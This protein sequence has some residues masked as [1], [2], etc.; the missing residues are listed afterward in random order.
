MLHDTNR[1]R[2]GL[3]ASGTRAPAATAAAALA[4]ALLGGGTAALAAGGPLS[5]SGNQIVDGTGTPVR[6]AGV[7]W[8]GFETGTHV[9]HGLWT[10]N[11]KELLQQVKDLGFNT[12]RI[13]WCNQAFEPGATTNSINTW[14]NPDLAG[15]SPIQVLDKIVDQCGVLGLRI[16]L[17]RHS[18]IADNFANED[19]WY[20]PGSGTW[21]EERWIADWVMLANRYAGNH[22]VIGA[23]LFNEPKRTATWGAGAPATDWNEAAERAGN[24]IL[25]ANPE[26]LIFV[27]GVEKANGQSTWWGGNL[28]AAATHPVTLD[29]PGRLVYSMHDYPASVYAQSWFGAPNYPA[30]LPGVWHGFWG[31]LFQENTAPLLLGEFGTKLQTVSDQQ[32][33]STLLAYAGGDFNLDGQ[34]DLTGNQKGMSWTYWSL[35]PNSGD[36]GGILADNWITVNQAKMT[37]LAGSLAPL[38]GSSCQGDLDGSGAVDGADLGSLLAAW[39]Q[40]GPADLDGSG[41]VDGA[42]LGTLLAAWGACP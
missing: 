38:I 36:T 17:D 14:A 20:I 31:Y 30:N 39:G 34:S 2:G 5:T 28:M 4:S 41:A 3:A 22:T 24:A 21:T 33:L 32:W 11:W 40:P 19:L 42:D 10:R 1:T 13:P 23:D 9:P 29:V 18:A 35:N 8:F 7:N 25:A 27:E 15:L 26:W 12:L 37:A 6:I 16:I